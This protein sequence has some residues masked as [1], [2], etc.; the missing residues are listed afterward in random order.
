MA[1]P[2]SGDTVKVHYTARLDDG[3]VFDSSK[4]RDPLELTIGEGKPFPGF[5]ETLTQMQPGEERTV[6][7]PADRGYGPH[8]P[9]LVLAVDR[10]EFPNDIQPRVGQQLQV[11]HEQGQVSVVTVADVSDEQVTLDANH[12]LAGRDLTLE[13]QLVEVAPR[14]S[15]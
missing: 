9:E 13:L 7:I 12:P 11:R 14:V 1:H 3:R 15:R 4:E 2:R 8:R 10:T 5:D 6:M